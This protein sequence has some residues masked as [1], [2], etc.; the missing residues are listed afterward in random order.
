MCMYVC[1][2]YVC[3]CILCMSV[4]NNH[5]LCVIYA[6]RIMCDVC[7]AYCVCMHLS[8]LRDIDKIIV[9]NLVL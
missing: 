9:V 3:M 7:I 5:V 4:C 8:Q 2:H 6:L 1:M